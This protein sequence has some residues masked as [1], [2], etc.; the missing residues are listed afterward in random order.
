MSPEIKGVDTLM[1]TSGH[2]FTVPSAQEVEIFLL[3]KRQFLL[4]QLRLDLE[5]EAR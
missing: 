3:Q 1:Y 5:E 4:M 2:C